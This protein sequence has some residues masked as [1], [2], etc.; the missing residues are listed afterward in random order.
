MDT[1]DK[2]QSG[3]ETTDFRY[4]TG[5][6]LFQGLST[7]EIEGIAQIT[8]QCVYES[9]SILCKQGTQGDDLYII[10]EGFVLIRQGAR[11]L[12]RL[13]PGEVVGEL[14]VFDNKPR[15]ADVVADGLVRVLVL[16]GQ[17][18]TSILRR[19]GNLPVKLLG[20][21]ANRIRDTNEQQERVGQLVRAYRERGHVLA[22]LD[23]LEIKK[24]QIHPELTLEYHGLSAKDLRSEF[25]V[26]LGNEV[27]R[28]N[29]DS[30]LDRLR[31]VYCNDIGVQYTHIDDLSV[32]FWL[33]ERLEN[34]KFYPVLQRDRQLRILSKLTE[35]E[36]FESF[37]QRT[38]SG[39]KRFSLEGA[40]TVIP[41][42]DEAIEKA[43]ALGVE[44]IVIGMAHRGRLNV[45]VNILGKPASRVFTEFEGT[46]TNMEEVMGD[47][48]YH[49][50]FAG[51]RLLAT[52]RTMRLSLCFNPSHLE[53]VSPV[54]L[55]E[56]RARQDRLQDI[57]GKR[58]LGIIIHGDAA[59]AGQGIVQELFNLSEL[60]GYS[61]GGA[62]HIIINN[63][64]GFTTPPEEGRS[65]Q[66]ATDVARMLQIPI[67]HV[68]GEK[69]E[70]VNKVVDLGLEFR[71]TFGRDVV[72]DM[73]CYRKHGHNEQ[74][75]PAFTQPLLYRVIGERESIR[76]AYAR[77][78]VN[79]GQIDNNEVREIEENSKQA[80]E[81]ELAKLGTDTTG[82]ESDE[83]SLWP[84]FQFR[85]GATTDGSEP[86]T[87]LSEEVL[88]E[89]LTQLATLPENFEL[90]PRVRL[91]FKGRQAMA[92]GKRP[93][94][95]GTAEALAFA[96]LLS[97]GV[98]VRLSGQ[99]SQRGTFAHRHAVV[100]D[101]S[102]GKPYVPLQ[103]FAGKEAFF[104]VLNSPLS[105]FGVL[106]FEFG[107]SLGF[108]DVLVIWEAQFG[109]FSNAA[110]VVID[111]FIS[112][113]E[114]KWGRFSG[115]CLLLPHGFEG[116]GPEHSH[117]RPERML[118]LAVNDNIQVVNPSTAS[119]FFHCL[120]RQMMR[121]WRK[122]LIVLTPKGSLQKRAIASGLDAFITGGFRTVIG[123]DALSETMHVK[124]LLLCSGKIYHELNAEKGK[125]GRDDI[126]IVR[127][128]QY[129]P[130]PRDAL[131]EVIQR[132][133]AHVSLA[134]VQEEPRN[135]GA[136]QFLRDHL[137][138]VTKL[139]RE[140]ECIA[141][142][143]SASPA[144]GSIAEHKLSQAHLINN[145]LDI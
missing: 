86:V 140:I 12:A 13:G 130:F 112:S 76:T 71:E 96:S 38:Y 62:V 72:I 29:L 16:H 120:R 20:I 60:N 44:E 137:N 24:P 145:A 82:L 123:D 32:Q 9:D 6:S 138:E 21:L 53:S 54:V 94:D 100:H 67:F 52:G 10:V 110:Q 37:L 59:F 98:S 7:D 109:D 92:S 50:G 74:D 131:Q 122:P 25:T 65:S 41:L 45:L 80:F 108:S 89:L 104:Q 119:Q 90:H 55:G 77:N 35:A 103:Q 121:T 106:G 33:R 136:W 116:Q 101:F 11:V 48:R 128:E 66:Y 113:S 58:V 75:E 49:Q 144:T 81:N 26:A 142:P 87:S 83:D 39:A 19:G 2:D 85:E 79:L 63:Q 70:A 64:I 88:S 28:A 14:A 17:N 73:Y 91:Q 132:Y 135:M 23:P 4:I 141:R 117:A 126:H 57:D 129:Y 36:I 22:K 8:R 95:W 105:E 15:S 69:P 124:R 68:N 111:Q 1:K 47:V 118:Q 51:D 34:D 84:Q 30:I 78:L 139:T 42:L 133:P 3:V 93:I 134:W 115:I 46:R 18:F 5:L 127:L 40:E 102:T 114:E 99:D 31:V 97:S 27:Q 125:Q 143:E 61:T 43:G 56:T 107:Y